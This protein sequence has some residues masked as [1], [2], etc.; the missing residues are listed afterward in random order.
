MSVEEMYS[1][2]KITI[3]TVMPLAVKIL[4]VSLH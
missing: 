1:V 3:S 4:Q 2:I